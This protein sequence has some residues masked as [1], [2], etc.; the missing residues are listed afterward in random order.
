MN[1]PQ[2][3]NPADL[4]PMTADDYAAAVEA[5]NFRLTHGPA[6]PRPAQDRLKRARRALYFRHIRAFAGERGAA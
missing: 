6:M 3:M 4:S 2:T 5:I 1:N